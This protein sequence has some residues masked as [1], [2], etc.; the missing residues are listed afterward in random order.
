F[1]EDDGI[2][3]KLVTGVQTCA[4]PIFG[5]KSRILRENALRRN[6]RELFQADDLAAGRVLVFGNPPFVAKANRSDSQNADHALVCSQIRRSEERR[7]GM[8]G[9]ETGRMAVE[10]RQ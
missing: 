3:S 9:L 7:V 10:R 8:M 5:N 4:L 2:R 6:W 1:H